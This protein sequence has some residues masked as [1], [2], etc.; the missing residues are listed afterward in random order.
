M[1]SQLQLEDLRKAQRELNE[2]FSFRR[3]INTTPDEEAFATNVETPRATQELQQVGSDAKKKIR[4]RVR[5][6]TIEEIVPDLEMPMTMADTDSTA[7]QRATTD[8][9]GIPTAAS[10]IANP[11]TDTDNFKAMTAEELAVIDNEFEQYT[12]ITANGFNEP[13][14]QDGA[15]NSSIGTTQD[16]TDDATAQSL[17]F[18]QQL[19]SN[20][21]NDSILKNQDKLEPLAQIMKQLALLEQERSA[22]TAR[23]KEEFAA[24]RELED[25]FYRKQRQVLEAGAAQVQQE[26]MYATTTT[27]TKTS[28]GNNE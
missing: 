26:V 8:W 14:L 28:V 18:Q 13:T 23:L 2:A 24:R 1:E 9:N 11:D 10:E 27:T 22:A 25:E 20:T 21:W 17:R 4:R 16:N 5:K 12:S 19:A 6:K 15:M 7:E 3:S